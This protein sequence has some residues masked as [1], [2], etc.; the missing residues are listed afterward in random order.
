ML[1][2]CLTKAHLFQRFVFLFTLPM[3]SMF[4]F[5]YKNTFFQFLY[6]FPPSF[7][8]IPVWIFALA[9]VLD[10]SRFKITNAFSFDFKM[11]FV[12]ISLFHS[13]WANVWF[14]TEKLFRGFTMTSRSVLFYICTALRPVSKT[15]QMLIEPA[16]FYAP[17]CA[18]SQGF[19]KNRVFSYHDIDAQ[20]YFGTVNK[21][22]FY[23][24]VY[25]FLKS[26][27]KFLL[28]GK[29]SQMNE[30]ELLYGK[31]HA[32]DVFCSNFL[33][34]VISYLKIQIMASRS[35]S[36]VSHST[37]GCFFEFYLVYSYSLGTSFKCFESSRYFP[38]QNGTQSAIE[39]YFS[40]LFYR[41]VWGGL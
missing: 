37:L 26:C 36:F 13:S 4:E 38:S 2:L 17:M 25:Q 31:V 41:K 30:I 14:R 33:I 21:R 10:S 24:P 6:G 34:V 20:W 23:S 16:F 32:P 15:Y 5:F 29:E 7:L 19:E 3:K 40:S 12:I 39:F 9:H 1:N 28:V 27:Q 22:F 11:L 8:E 18:C 35:F